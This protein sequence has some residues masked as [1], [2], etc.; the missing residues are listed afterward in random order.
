MPMPE[1]KPVKM[2][3]FK[4]REKREETNT[5]TV[6]DKP[7]PLR[8]DLVNHSNEFDWGYGGS[9]PAQT[10]LAILAE[11]YGDQIAQ[12]VHQEFKWQVIA[13]QEG[14]DFGMNSLMIDGWMHDNHYLDG[15]G[16]NG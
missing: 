4:R 16:T 14:S 5:I 11:L 12:R 8:Q 10:A 6:N 7:L 1:P 2:F 15:G 3:W 13:R 9:G